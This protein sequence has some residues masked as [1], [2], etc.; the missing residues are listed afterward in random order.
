MARKS[1]QATESLLASGAAAAFLTGVLAAAAETFRWRGETLALFVKR[2]PDVPKGLQPA[3]KSAMRQVGEMARALIATADAIERALQMTA[4][5]P[6]AM[7]D[8][9]VL[10]EARRAFAGYCDAEQRGTA[11]FQALL[12][13]VLARTRPAGRA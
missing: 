6:V 12:D 2:P 1:A 11:T 3:V 13:G 10:E 7:L 8:V 5:S 4:E 9:D